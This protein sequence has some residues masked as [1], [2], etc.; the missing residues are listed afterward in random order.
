MSKMISVASGFQ[1]SVNIGFDLGN[2][3]KLINFIPTRSALALLEE[4]L[5]STTPSSSERARILIGAYGKGKSHIVLTILSM[6][7]QRDKSLF[8]KI[9]EKAASNPR[10]LHAID[11]YYDSGRKILPVVISGSNTSLNQAFLLALQRTL[12][13]NDLLDVMPE[14]NYRA[15][16]NVIKRWEAEYPETY[17]Q[18]AQLI[19]TSV[20]MFVAA[21]EDYDSS[22]YEAFEK[23]YP[24]LTAGSS[25]NPFL[26][27][28][29]VELYENAA[30]GL[31]AKG[32]AGIYVVY[33][34][35]SKFLEANI[36]DASV[37]DTKMLQD[38][39]EKCNRS[40]DNQ[41]HLMLISHKEVA[42]Y[43]D[44]LPKHKVDGWRGVSERFKHIHLNNNFTQTYEII[45]SVI[46]KN[47]S[48]AGYCNR[49]L[50]AFSD[51]I[52]RYTRHPL[53]SDMD[54]EQV[55]AAV[56]QCYPL[57]PV[58]TYILPRLSERVAQNERTLFT[59]LSAEGSSTLRAFLSGFDDTSFQTVSPDLIYDYFEPLFR[60]E[61]YEGTIHKTYLLTEAILGQLPNDSLEGK[62]VKTISLVYILEQY[63]KLK[64]TTDELIGIFRISYKLEAIQEAIAQLIDKKFLV[65]RKRSNNYL[66]LK[67]SS[68]VNI[69]DRI[70]DMIETQRR[71]VAVKDTLN[72]ANFDNYIYP[73][74]YNDEKEMTRYFSFEFI[75]G[76]AIEHGVDWNAQYKASAADGM[77]FGI[78]P[79][80]TDSIPALTQRLIEESKLCKSVIF[81]IPKKFTSIEDSVREL[82]AVTHLRDEAAGD[83]ILFDEY[84]VIYEDLIEVI[85]SF[86]SIYTHPERQKAIYIQGGTVKSIQRKAALTKLASDMCNELFSSTPTISNEVINR[87]EL[88][89]IASTSRA[90][91]IAALLRTE[92]EPNLGLSGTGQEVSIMRSTLIRTDV[93]QDVDSHPHINLHPTDENMA[94]LLSTIE[95]F[96]FSAHESENVS[97]ADLYIRLTSAEYGIGLRL[98]LIPIYI[99]AVLHEYKQSILLYD[100]VG[101]VPLNADTLMQINAQPSGFSLVYVN[102][103]IDKEQYVSTLA[104]IFSE[105]VVEAER[106][107]SPYDYVANAMRRWYMDLPRFTKEAKRDLQNESLKK[108]NPL[109]RCLKAAASSYQLLFDEL[110]SAFGYAAFTRNVEENIRSAKHVY[111]ELLVNL[112]AHLIEST[113]KLFSLPTDD[114]SVIARKSLSSC[115]KDWCETLDS[116]AFTQL[117]PDGTERF[118]EL[119]TTASNDD[120]SLVL[121]LAKLATG[122]RIEDWDN[123][124]IKTF[125]DV[126]YARK[127]TAEQFHSQPQKEDLSSNSNGS[128][129]DTYQLTFVDDRGTATT[130][131]FKRVD[132]S[133]R[134]RL[135]TNQ[136]TSALSSM[137]QSISEQEKRQVLMDI[138]K[139]LC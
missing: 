37:S 31:R 85:S 27:F 62:L 100:R 137:G 75:E 48:W 52:Q 7:M 127:N 53:F 46:K 24:L 113:K 25:F 77:V 39:A 58:S 103:D 64:P 43:I 76:A 38:F 4:V 23:A 28:D 54:E 6:L 19:D 87:N 71:T 101:Q 133:P 26:G 106:N 1:Y 66:Q 29:V 33:D 93:L 16:V 82:N 119:F 35:F 5:L 14:T 117:F 90:K 30:K 65:Y 88:T 51:L 95:G 81:V 15:A 9:L 91:L 36:T 115:V 83:K 56:Y 96:I 128:E 134:A 50:T 18:L 135:L 116:G 102:W 8:P 124:Y 13:Q 98:G 45:G 41:M 126:L 129:S 109:M 21:L 74:Q 10:L 112:R 139:K 3:D 79:E 57:H 61:A 2:D 86:L 69:R 11:S 34:E 105:Y 72:S 131:R 118:L 42:N 108:Y 94:N 70:H 32:Y 138:I 111:D 59:F 136:I 40:G 47:E 78:L 104:T 55:N 125:T 130:K 17:A 68:G 67:Q 89:G 97:F 120:D 114:K 80:S 122:L 121:R 123:S 60:K 99:A 107:L 84:E 132:I 20:E 44:K 63:E 110:P 92:L 22:A 12:S 49:H 73:S